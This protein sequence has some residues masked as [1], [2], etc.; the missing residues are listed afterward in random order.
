MAISRSRPAYRVVDAERRGAKMKKRLAVD[1]VEA[2][3]VQLIFRLY[4]EG[5][6]SSPPLGVKETVKWLN[7]RGYRT[8]KGATFGVG[9]LHKILT[10]RCYAFGKCAYGV[11]NARTG[12]LNDPSQVVEIDVPTILAVET[13]EKV[14]ARLAR[15]HP[16]VTPPRIV[17]GPILLTGLAVCATC[18]AGMTR[19]GTRRGAR[20]YAYYSC[21]GCHQKG[22]AVCKGRH[23]PMAR[24]DELV[25]ASVKERLLTPE[26]L[27]AV[28]ETLVRRRSERDEE[29][30][31]RRRAL[32]G[33]LAEKKDR[34]ARLYR[35][36]EEGL[37]DL[38]DDLGARIRD[39]KAARDV[40]QGSLERIEVQAAHRDQI[41][42]ERIEAF[43]ALVRDKLDTGDI[44][45][46][47]AYLRSVISRIEV[48]DRVVRI[49][50]E[51]AALADVIAGRGTQPNRVRG[52]DRKWR[53]RSDSNARPSDS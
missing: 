7:A 20:A 38:D 22:P 46:R 13:F 51:K 36:I 16:R 2:E 11:R 31:R 25:V 23:V 40:I 1:P 48:D 6:G 39:L 14:Q 12:E 4:L 21:A 28:L 5:D 47:K 26:R 15:N 45:A 35:A 52:F 50:G 53:A 34:L 24:L 3:T 29:V 18:G 49:I 8:R 33:E 37:V 10:N 44:H 32:E 43:A 42:P 41:T 19:T 17:N 9:P 30:A 27:G